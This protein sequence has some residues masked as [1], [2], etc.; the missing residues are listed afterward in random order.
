MFFERVAKGKVGVDAVVVATADPL[1][2]RV[3]R[4]CEL[5]ATGRSC[6]SMLEAL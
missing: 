1:V 5:G 2:R 6:T 4:A 3:A